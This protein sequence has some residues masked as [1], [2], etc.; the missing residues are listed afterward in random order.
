MTSSRKTEDEE[1]GPRAEDGADEDASG[2]AEDEAGED[3]SGRAE[4]DG[5]GAGE[6]ACGVRR[7][8]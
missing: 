4:D 5:A 8:S 6:D 1:E 2:R 7:W 3:A